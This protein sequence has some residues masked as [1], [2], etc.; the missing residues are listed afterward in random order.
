VLEALSPD[1][2]ASGDVLPLEIY[3]D[4]IEAEQGFILVRPGAPNLPVT[5]LVDVGPRRVDGLLDLVGAHAGPHDMI[6]EIGSFEVARLEN[7]FGVGDPAPCDGDEELAAAPY[8]ALVDGSPRKAAF[9]GHGRARWVSLSYIHDTGHHAIYAGTMIADQEWDDRRYH[10]TDDLREVTCA[11]GPGEL[12]HIVFVRESAGTDHLVYIRDDDTGSQTHELPVVDGA[13]NPA[14]AVDSTGNVHIVFESDIMGESWLFT[15]TAGPG[16]FGGQTDLMSGAGAEQPDL[17]R[18]A[19]GLTLTF[20]RDSWLPGFHEVCRQRFDGAAWGAPVVMYSGLSIWS[21]SVAWNGEDLLFAFILDNVL[22]APLLHTMCVSGGTAG[23]VRWRT[24]P[25]DRT[26]SCMVSAT[27]PGRF[28][29][30]T[31]ESII[32]GMLAVLHLRSG[33]GRTFGAP[34]Q[35]NT[36][37]DAYVGHFAADPVRENLFAYWLDFD[38]TLHPFRFWRCF[39]FASGV[40]DHTGDTP[41]VLTSLDCRPNPFNPR[42]EIGFGLVRGGHVRLDVYDTRGRLVRTLLDETRGAGEH[43]VVWDG[44]DGSG[45]T[46]SAGVYVSELRAEGR[47][48]RRKMLLLK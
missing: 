45:R 34:R 21:P 31:N 26:T 42:T 44:R 22:Y 8:T 27:V 12:L 10:T 37:T 7:A 17:C 16:G 30:V 4:Y 18:S 41:L 36:S 35:L 1:G 23:P 33:D 20:V 48:E 46:V 32:G 29:L 3:G 24:S 5:G 43:S 38:N 28:H 15:T 11:A 2:G 9:D 6:V 39:R 25:L 14:V 13:R 47:N 19:G 40:G